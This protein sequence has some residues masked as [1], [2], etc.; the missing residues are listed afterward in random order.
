MIVNHLTKQ[1]D[2]LLDMPVSFLPS[3]T[4]SCECLLTMCGLSLCCGQACTGA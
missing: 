2:T 1:C 3:S 4:A